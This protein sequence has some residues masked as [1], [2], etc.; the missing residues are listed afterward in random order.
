VFGV[1]LVARDAVRP[2]TN[3]QIR[4]VETFADQAVIAIENTR[5]FEAE[6]AS[7]RE[8]QESLEY[9]TATSEVLGV[10]SRSPTE[11]QPV[12][13]SIAATAARLCESVDAP[14]YRAGCWPLA[15]FSSRLR[16]LLLPHRPRSTP[17]C[18]QS[19]GAEDVSGGS[20]A[21]VGIAAGLAQ[22]PQASGSNPLPMRSARSRVRGSR[23][24]PAATA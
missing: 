3:R 21:S 23:A 14:V 22:E 19:S 17:R 12:L 5:L 1:I 6:Q 8:L 9:Q 24:D 4:L 13:D 10:I 11:L 15:S 18:I 2:F 20:T 16:V 7:K